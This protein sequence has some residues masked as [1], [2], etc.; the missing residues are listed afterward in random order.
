MPKT[1]PIRVYESEWEWLMNH[2]TSKEKS[3]P[4]VIRGLIRF[5]EELDAQR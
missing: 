3:I 2:R 1:I 4:E 5:K